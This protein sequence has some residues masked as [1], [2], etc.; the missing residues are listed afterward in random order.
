MRQ[1]DLTVT[2]NESRTPIWIGRGILERVGELLPLSTYSRV[3]IVADAGPSK[4]I[5]RIRA[6]TNSLPSNLL[7]LEGGEGGKEIGGLTRVWEFFAQSKLDRRSLVIAIGGGATSDL[8][9]F[10]ASTYMRGVSLLTIPTTLLAQV[11]AS[12]GGKNGINF[13][14]IKNVLGTISQPSGILID[15]ETLSTLPDRELRSGFAEVIKHG[16]IADREYFTRVTSR[17]YSTWSPQELEEIV[18]RSCEL[19]RAI[20]ESDESE[21]GPRKMLNFGHTIGHAIESFFLS[22]PTPLT[23]GEAISIGMVAEATIAQQKGSMSASDLQVITSALDAAGLPTKLPDAVPLE[24]LQT[25]MAKDKKNVGGAIRWSLLNA[26]GNG[27]FDQIVP[28][29]IVANALASIQPRKP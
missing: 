6:T 13:H 24:E 21:R 4:A 28:Q 29:E 19:K 11:D 1:L 20:V 8:V 12:V 27:N 14:G 2:R 3:A 10:A 16:V 26:I 15:I 25:L 23:H 17:H 18:F 9:G 22:R 5:E 7:I